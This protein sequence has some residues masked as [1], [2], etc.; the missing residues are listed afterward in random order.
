MDVGKFKSSRLRLTLWI[1]FPLMLAVGMGLSSY[2]LRRHSEWK[3]HRTEVLA[4]ML[5]K[6]IKAQEGVH[7]LMKEFHGIQGESIQSEDQFIS[8][9]QNA[10]NDAEFTVNSLKVE[11]RVSARN[12]NLPVLVARVRGLGTFQTVE[13]YLGSVT[14]KQHLL[15]EESLKISQADR[16]EDA[17]VCLADITF[18]LILFKGIGSRE[19]GGA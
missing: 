1:L 9:L 11:R 18:E 6:L 4:E 19:K 14:F 3:L 2:A 8:F 7:G 15:T 12:N 17:G 16:S 13:K 5:P 10:A